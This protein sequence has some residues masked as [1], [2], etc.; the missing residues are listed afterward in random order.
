LGHP[1]GGMIPTAIEDGGAGKKRSIKKEDEGNKD[2]SV[3]KTIFPLVNC[4]ESK[5]LYKQSQLNVDYRCF[6]RLPRGGRAERGHDL[7]AP[8]GFGQG[9]KT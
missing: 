7:N 2:L 5:G 4:E 3:G 1:A 9:K 6:G 8:R